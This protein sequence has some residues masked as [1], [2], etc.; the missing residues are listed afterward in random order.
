M[1][2]QFVDFDRDGQLDIVVGIFD[3][4]PHVARG[5]QNGY[6]APEQI[7]DKNGERIVLNAFWNLGKKQ[8]EDTHR[9]DA[10]GTAPQGAHATSAVVFDVDGDG[11]LDLLL[12]DHKS[13]N[14]YVRHNE[15]GAGQPSFGTVNTLLHAGGA[16]IDVP[17]T[18]ATLRLFDWDRDGRT[19]LLI[20]SMGDAYSGTGDG[21]GGFLFRNE[22]STKAAAFGKS[23]TLIPVGKKDAIDAPAR[24][25]SGLYLDAGDIDGDGDPDLVVG[26]YS[27]WTP[28]AK[29][30]TAAQQQRVEAIRAELAKLAAELQALDETAQKSVAGLPKE[31]ASKRY[32]AAYQAQ[33]QARDAN[34]AA[35]APL[36]QELAALVPP[37]QR[38]SL[39]WIYTNTTG[40]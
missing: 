25:D 16:P 32:T 29:A 9:F 33:K 21:G 4:S 6:G 7:V 12:G 39:V 15:G 11:D 1:S 8:W 13:G 38:R 26:G 20:G 5:D 34:R 18:V 10:P 24:P 22:G 2:P 31:E 30:L 27:H 28:K 14:V 3:G 17:G 35:R 23:V 19:D 37:A 40:P 36:D